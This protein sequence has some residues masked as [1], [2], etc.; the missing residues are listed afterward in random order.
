MQFNCELLSDE[1]LEKPV[2]ISMEVVDELKL[3]KVFVDN[4]RLELQVWFKMISSCINISTESNTM[5]DIFFF[6]L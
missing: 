4:K 1:L 6:P 5:D 3:G 2:Q